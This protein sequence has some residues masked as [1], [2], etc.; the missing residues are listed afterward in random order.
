MPRFN[1]LMPRLKSY[2]L[3][4][5]CK[6]PAQCHLTDSLPFSMLIGPLGFDCY[7]EFLMSLSISFIYHFPGGILLLFISLEKYEFSVDL[8]SAVIGVHIFLVRLRE[9][10]FVIMLCVTQ[11][12]LPLFVFLHSTLSISTFYIHYTI[13]L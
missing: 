10:E 4:Q 8:C 1:V 13:L 11:I 6:C 5:D 7:L 9:G 2:W 3:V 12:Q